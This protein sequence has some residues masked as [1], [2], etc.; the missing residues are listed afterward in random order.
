MERPTPLLPQTAREAARRYLA[1]HPDVTERQAVTAMCQQDIFRRYL[2]PESMAV[3]AYLAERR[4][5]GVRAVRAA[6][7]GL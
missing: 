7:S 4:R 2:S 3:R 5:H 6:T 1:D